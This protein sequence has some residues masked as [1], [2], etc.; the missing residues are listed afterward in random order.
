MKPRYLLLAVGCLLSAAFGQSYIGRVDT[1]GGTTYDWQSNAQAAKDLAGS[2]GHGMHALW[3]YST[4]TSGTM[5]DDRNMRYNFYD[6]NTRTWNWIDPDYMQSGVNVFPHRAGYGNIDADPTSGVAIVG[7]HYTGSGGVAPE[8]AKDAASGA[9]IFDYAD[10]PGSQ[11]PRIA[12]GQN[13]TIHIF[14]CSAGYGLCYTRIRGGGWPDFDTL[15]VVDPSGDFP[16][17]A[18]AASK[19]SGRACLIWEMSTNVPE[20]G[21]IQTSTDNGDS[22]TESQQF[23]PPNAF[24]G[25]TVTS[26]HIT[27]LCPWYDYEDQLHVVANVSPMVHDTTYVVPSQIW[28]WCPDNTPQWSRVHIAA[29][30]PEHM[31]ASVGYNATY[32]DRPSIG[33]GNDGWLYVAWEQF[34]SSNVEPLTSRL[35]AGIWYSRSSDNGAS[36]MPGELVTGRNTFSHRFPSI[37]D[38]M[39]P[40][41]MAD[42]ICILYMMDSVAGFFVQSEGPATLNPVVCQFIPFWDGVQEATNAELRTTNVEP[43]IIRGVLV[44]EARGKRREARG[45][46]LDISGR[47]VLDLK[48][49]ANDVHSLAP[50]VYFVREEPQ[51]ASLKLQAVRKIVITR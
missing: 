31:Q 16:T 2:P 40:G 15:R 10:G 47:K 4:A 17:H 18:V 3:M 49:R 38:R 12:T 23:L 41:E 34:D 7:G 43:T 6:F 28:H 25:D 36:W 9:G 33:E 11:W 32:A 21:Y 39:L 19:V 14:M 13:G 48:P 35:R 30:R 5:F 42:T 46:L 45:E 26:F 51:A 1:I 27:S 22:W 24:G 50:G 37:I 44:F 8:V 29:C 20:D